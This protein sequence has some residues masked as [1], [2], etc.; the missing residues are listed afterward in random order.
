MRDRY[1]RDMEVVD[2][3]RA[4]LAL[5]RKMRADAVVGTLAGSLLNGQVVEF[6]SDVTPVPLPLDVGARVLLL[7][8]PDSTEDDDE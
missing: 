6:G 7:P 5:V 8:L 2:E 1:D 3:A 4:A